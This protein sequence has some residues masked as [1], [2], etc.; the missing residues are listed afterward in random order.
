MEG[1]QNDFSISLEND[2]SREKLSFPHLK[3]STPKFWDIENPLTH[4]TKSK[5]T[6]HKYIETFDAKG[7]HTSKWLES[8]D[9]CL[10]MYVCVWIVCMRSFFAFL[11]GTRSRLY[12]ILFNGTHHLFPKN[13]NFIMKSNWNQTEKKKFTNCQKRNWTFAIQL[14]D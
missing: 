5:K 10:L 9:K 13:L 6:S 14:F 1:M 11:T 12:A 8:R 7:P 3:I 4:M 2:F